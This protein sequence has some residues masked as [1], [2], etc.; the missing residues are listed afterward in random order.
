MPDMTE[1]EF[2]RNAVEQGLRSHTWLLENAMLNQLNEGNHSDQLK[3]SISTQ[4][5]LEKING[6]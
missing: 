4:E 5:M 6:G 2:L 3:H 1:L